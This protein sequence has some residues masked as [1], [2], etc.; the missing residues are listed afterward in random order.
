MHIFAGILLALSLILA[1]IY[2]REIHGDAPDNES[3]YFKLRVVK[4]ISFITAFAALGGLLYDQNSRLLGLT[5]IPLVI[6]MVIAGLV[7]LGAHYRTQ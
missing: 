7:A 6:A 4:L 2:R 1:V 3:Y 5:D